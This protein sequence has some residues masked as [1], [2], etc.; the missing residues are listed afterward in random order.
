MP[1]VLI[2]GEKEYAD[3]TFPVGELFVVA[4]KTTLKD[5]W[6]QVLKEGPRVKRRYLVT[7]QPGISKALLN[8]MHA[9]GIVLVVPKEIQKEYPRSDMTILT[10]EQFIALVMQ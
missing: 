7:V 2:P 10:V 9:A 1:D 3:S 6:G 5:R 8:R 4:V